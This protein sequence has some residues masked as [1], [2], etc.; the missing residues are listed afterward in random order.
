MIAAGCDV[1]SLTVKTVILKDNKL[2]GYDIVPAT[3]NAVQSASDAMDHLLE[4][5]NL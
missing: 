2:L 4:K 1:G 5:L 3:S